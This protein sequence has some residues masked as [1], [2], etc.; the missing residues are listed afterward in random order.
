M[1]KY[2]FGLLIS[3]L[4]VCGCAPSNKPSDL[5]PLFPCAL[6][7]TMDGKPLE[8]ASITLY[9]NDPALAKYTAGGITDAMGKVVLRTNGQFPGA[10]AGSFKIVVLKDSKPASEDSNRDPNTPPPPQ[11]PVK[12]LIDKTFT[13][14][15]SSPLEITVAEGNNEEKTFEVKPAK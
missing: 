1:N 5:P 11:K 13:S 4:F 8:E 12:S 9:P 7:F 10:P 14:A 3:L 6:A 2:Y 15:A